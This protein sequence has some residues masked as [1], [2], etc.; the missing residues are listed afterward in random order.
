MAGLV[1]STII[2]PDGTQ[3]Q[4]KTTCCLTDTGY[5]CCPY[6]SAVCCPD[7]AHCCPADYHCNME[8]QMCERRGM[9]WYRFPS[10]PQVSA[11]DPEDIA[12]TPPIESLN[13][14]VS[15]VHCDNYHVCPDGTTCCRSPS[16]FWSCCIYNMGQCCP[17]GVAC[18]PYGYKCDS[19]STKCFKGTLSMPSSPKIAAIPSNTVQVSAEEPEEIASTPLIES[20]NSSVS[21]VHCDNYHVCPDGTTCCRSPSGFW[22]C[23]IYNMGQCCP[24]GVACCPYGY[25]CDSTSTKCFKGT[26]SMP[27]SPKIAAIPSN[28]VQDPCCLSETGCCPFGYSCDEEQKSCVIKPALV[29]P[30]KQ[31]SDLNMPAGIIRCSGQFYCPA[32]HTC[33][34]TLTGQW[35]CCP[36]SLG[37]CCK[38]GKHCCKYGYNCNSTFTKCTKHYLTIP[39]RLKKKALIL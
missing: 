9:P 11:E 33:C 24:N 39:A 38:D 2:C 30:P 16:G 31:A 37:Q 20:L 18:C 12:S 34:K 22:S 32:G 28:T 13:S 21:V 19:T 14:S 7:K 26:L 27:S 4:D 35:A 10:T 5:S 15:V 25:K 1:S 17:N 6:P 8:S 36:Y 3:C 23:C 29:T